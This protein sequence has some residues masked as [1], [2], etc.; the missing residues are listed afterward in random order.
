M[1]AKSKSVSLSVRVPLAYKEALKSM[2]RPP[3]ITYSDLVREAIYL[4][5]K[6]KGVIKDE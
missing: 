4:F 6:E 1:D 2:L 3:N 5:L